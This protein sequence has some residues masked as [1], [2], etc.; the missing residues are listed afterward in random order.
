MSDDETNSVSLVVP[1]TP[2]RHVMRL[3]RGVADLFILMTPYTHDE[4]RALAQAIE[5]NTTLTLL[6][7]GDVAMTLADVRLIVDACLRTKAPLKSLT[8]SG[9]GLGLQ[10]ARVVA[11]L[12]AAKPLQY[13]CLERNNIGDEGCIAVADA[14]RRRRARI[15]VVMGLWLTNNGIGDAGLTAIAETIEDTDTIKTLCVTSNVM[16]MAGAR[17]LGRAILMSKTPTDVLIGPARPIADLIW[18][19]LRRSRHDLFR[20]LAFV[21]AADLRPVHKKLGHAKRF[22]RACGDMGVLRIVFAMLAVPPGQ[23]DPPL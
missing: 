10:G 9:C 1:R 20:M 11:E 4:F 19:C 16:T 12:V 21:S 3:D 17:R 7:V 14:V 23:W 2:S 13:V 22:V 6:Y 15:N 8:L 5:R 18:Y